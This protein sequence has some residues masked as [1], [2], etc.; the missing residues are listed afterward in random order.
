MRKRRS[1]PLISHY[2][3]KEN[4]NEYMGRNKTSDSQ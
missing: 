3:N 4:F 1:I 2:Y